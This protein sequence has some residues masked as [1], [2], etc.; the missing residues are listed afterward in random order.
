MS[1]VIDY[2]A[3]WFQE[4]APSS[5]YS[6]SDLERTIILNL[7][8]IFPEYT[9]VI[10]KDYLI[11]RRT[12]RKNRADLCMVKSDYSEW[13]V[14]EVELG[15]HAIGE[16]LNQIDTFNDC[17]Y[18]ALHAKSIYDKKPSAFDLAKLTHLVTTTAP[19]LM[20]IVNEDKRSW[21]KK[22]ANLNCK[23][24]LFQIYNDFEGRRMFRLD[25]EHPF[26]YTDF[27]ECTFLKEVPFAVKVL[28]A[29][30]LDAYGVPNRSS[31]MIEYEGVNHLWER[32]DDSEEVFLICNT[33]FPPL[34]PLTH[35]YRLNFNKASWNKP[36]S[37]NL[38]S[39]LLDLLKKNVASKKVN[40]FSFTRQES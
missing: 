34:D 4:V 3:N 35:R 33:R 36:K 22:L 40:T 14:I 27:C 21:K 17:D 10:F 7:H 18:T 26:I 9:A 8:L 38:L 12:L 16:V 39:C 2:N 6:E 1:K 37:N 24:C 13:Y 29:D 28:K 30:F 31:V 32:Q 11:H 25:G 20:V 5:F 19:L 23:L 15:S